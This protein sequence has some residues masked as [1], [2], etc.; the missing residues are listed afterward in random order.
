MQTREVVE[1]IYV[2]WSHGDAAHGLMGVGFAWHDPAHVG[3]AG[4][5]AGARFEIREMA[6]EGDRA[7]VVVHERGEDGA[8]RTLFH[9]WVVRDGHAVECVVRGAEAADTP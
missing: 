7:S 1:A 6:V 2:A 5:P 9:R 3:P 8:E 4:P